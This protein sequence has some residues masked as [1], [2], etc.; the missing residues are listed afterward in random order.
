MLSGDTPKSRFGISST[1]YCRLRTTKQ[2]IAI[3]MAT[4]KNVTEIT[5]AMMAVTCPSLRSCAAGG[6]SGAVA[7]S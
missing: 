5:D 3:E 6:M 2:R 7:K 4:T 1:Q